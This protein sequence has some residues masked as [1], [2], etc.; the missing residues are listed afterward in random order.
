MGSDGEHSS[1]T[2]GSVGRRSLVAALLRRV[3][4]RGVIA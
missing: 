4:V 1:R 2:T 3:G